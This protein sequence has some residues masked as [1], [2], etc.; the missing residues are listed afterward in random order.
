MLEY[1]EIGLSG[2][3]ASAITFGA[4]SI[5]EVSRCTFPTVSPSAPNPTSD[6]SPKTVSYSDSI[7]M[8][9]STSYEFMF[10]YYDILFNKRL[11]WKS[12]F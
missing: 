6:E 1:K 10:S 4:M 11:V 2:I 3:R 9:K 12:I 7:F 5:G 8:F